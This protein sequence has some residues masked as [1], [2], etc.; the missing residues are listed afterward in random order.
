[1]RSRIFASRIMLTYICITL[2][3]YRKKI[4]AVNSQHSALRQQTLEEHRG[5]HLDK[6]IRTIRVCEACKVGEE[7]KKK[8]EK[9]KCGVVIT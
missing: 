7:K 8:K 4:V 2:T 6:T 1:M 9:K 5:N 3:L